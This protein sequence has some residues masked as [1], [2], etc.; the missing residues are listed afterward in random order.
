[1]KR[2]GFIATLAALPVIAASFWKPPSVFAKHVRQSMARLNGNGIPH[3]ER[4]ATASMPYAVLEDRDA[5]HERAEQCRVAMIEELR[6][7]GAPINVWRVGQMRGITARPINFLTDAPI[8]WKDEHFFCVRTRASV[9]A[10][11]FTHPLR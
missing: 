1:M 6:K 3:V 4:A 2:R 9:E 10:T 8:P 11:P 5:F 7:V